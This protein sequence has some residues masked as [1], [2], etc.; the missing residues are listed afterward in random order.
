MDLVKQLNEMYRI[1]I[2]YYINEDPRKANHFQ[3]KLTSLLTN[4]YTLNLIEKDKKPTSSK[5]S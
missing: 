3:K 1:A 4:P 2:E 5:Q